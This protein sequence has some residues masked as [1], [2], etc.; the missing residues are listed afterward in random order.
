MLWQG[1]CFSQQLELG[2]GIIHPVS[3]SSGVN[4][5]T[6]AG[7]PTGKRFT[8][9]LSLDFS[10]LQNRYV[11]HERIID[12]GRWNR[13]KLKEDTFYNVLETNRFSSIEL[14]LEPRFYSSNKNPG[15]FFSP[16]IGIGLFRQKNSFTKLDPDYSESGDFMALNPSFGIEFGLE[17][18]IRNSNQLSFQI[19]FSTKLYLGF[20][21]TDNYIPPYTQSKLILKGRVGF[22]WRLQD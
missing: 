7:Y 8:I 13:P 17:F 12:W 22:V 16:S 5:H 21:F 19:D 10:R 15:F 11:E 9:G 20:P 4:V 3:F 2:I 18:P 1:P 14:A 6:F